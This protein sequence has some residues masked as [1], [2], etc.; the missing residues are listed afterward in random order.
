M[1]LAFLL[2]FG[3]TSELIG[4]PAVVGMGLFVFFNNRRHHPGHD[5]YLAQENTQFAVIPDARQPQV[6]R[7][8]QQH[9]LSKG[10]PR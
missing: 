10:D 5:R 8:P 3:L 4:I 1:P 9:L 6:L 7:T 2:P